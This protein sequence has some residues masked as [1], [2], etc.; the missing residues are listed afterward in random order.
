MLYG[1]KCYTLVGATSRI[2][3]SHLLSPYIFISGPLGRSA[4]SR[5]LGRSVISGPLG[6]SVISGPIGRSVISGPMAVLCITG[7]KATRLR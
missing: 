4:I 1:T 6:R 7:L 2:R 3:K 5:P